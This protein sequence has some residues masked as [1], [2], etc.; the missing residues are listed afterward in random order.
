MPMSDD[1]LRHLLTE[2]QTLAVVGLS[3]R[4]E[5]DSHQIAAY[6]QSQGYRIVP[7]NPSVREVLG[8]RSYASLSAIPPELRVDLAVVFRR[9]EA[10]PEI[11]AEAIARKV[12]TLWFQPGVEH[13]AAARTAREHGITVVEGLC[14]R[15]E[16][17]TLGVRP[18]GAAA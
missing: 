12:P 10:L 2:A 11:V 18:R 7:V 6:L 15:T 5:R 14:S 8:E 3:E 13:P 9:G 1:E 17:R 16:H 4:P